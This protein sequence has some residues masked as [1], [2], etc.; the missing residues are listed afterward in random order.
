M[1]EAARRCFH[2]RFQVGQVAETLVRILGGHPPAGASPTP[3]GS[4]PADYRNAVQ[5]P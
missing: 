1:R 4:A 2:A 3:A 5:D